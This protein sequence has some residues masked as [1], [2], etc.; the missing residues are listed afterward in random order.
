MPGQPGE[1]LW[2]YISDEDLW[3]NHEYSMINARSDV[4]RLF[5]Y[6]ATSL[7]GSVDASEWMADFDLMGLT[8]KGNVGYLYFQAVP[9]ETSYE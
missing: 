8:I 7:C 3:E 5:R 2:R 4:M 1:Y 9:Q 6:V